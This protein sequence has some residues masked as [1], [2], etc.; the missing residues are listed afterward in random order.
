MISSHQVA[1]GYLKRPEEN[2]KTFVDNPYGEGEYAR[3]YRT[4]GAC[5]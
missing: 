3:M 5:L 2:A 4:G 1:R